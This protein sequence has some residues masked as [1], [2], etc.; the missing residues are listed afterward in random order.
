MRIPVHKGIHFQPFFYIVSRI[1]ARTMIS[2]MASKISIILAWIFW[3][4]AH[5]GIIS[6]YQQPGL[7]IVA[8]VGVS[9]LILAFIATGA[10]F[11]IR[12]YKPGARQLPFVIITVLLLGWVHTMAVQEILSN[13]LPDE[14][15]YL[16]FIHQ[17]FYIRLVLATL[18]I[19]LSVVTGWLMRYQQESDEEKERVRELMKLVSS[20][21]QANLL[22]KI[23]PHFLF[24]TLN[25]V[26]SLMQE[27]VEA[28]GKMI[29]QLSDF[30]R[31]SLKNNPDQISTLAAELEQIRLYLEIEK[32]RFGSRLS[33]E[34]DVPR[35]LMAEKVPSLI[36]Q[37]L[38]ENSIKFGLYDTLGPVTIKLSVKKQPDFLSI[39]VS[40]PFDMESSSK[41]KGTGF[42]LK[43]LQRRLYLLYGRNDL[44]ETESVENLFITTV[45]IPGA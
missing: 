11:T 13:I 10:G 7:A 15:V 39:R 16:Q 6:I 20:S 14:Q 31:G 32:V 28:A 22:M 36:M 25:S 1:N 42:G 5:Y 29:G 12:Y 18:I 21:E 38:I 24:N 41:S 2:G 43:S 27:N 17:S 40:N 35:E 19:A 34:F 33:S 37:P 30:L 26:H 44:V 23:Q 3:S 45:N 4:I 9:T 8:E